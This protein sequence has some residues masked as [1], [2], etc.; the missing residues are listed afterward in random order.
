MQEALD[1]LPPQYAESIANVEFGVKRAPSRLDRQRLRLRGH[2]YGLYEGVPLTRRDSSYDKVMPDR[3][4]LY[5]GTL[6]RD[7]SDPAD[8][9]DQVRK[10]V[11]HEIGH[12][13]GLEEAD[14]HHT[15]VE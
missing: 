7:F 14:L 2:L 6:T 12:Y 11:Y 13:F 3:I 4:T 10:T 8:L 15:S 5:W 9:A 1:G